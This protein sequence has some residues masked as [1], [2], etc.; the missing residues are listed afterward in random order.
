MKAILL[1][2]MM[3]LFV[4][5]STTTSFK[6]PKGADL[7]IDE[8]KVETA[9]LGKYKRNPFFWTRAQGIPYRLEKKGKVI[10]E[11]KIKARFRVASI[12]WPPA[13]IIYWPL[14]FEEPE[15]DFTKA[16]SL[17]RPEDDYLK[18]KHRK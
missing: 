16:N 11:G 4:G 15:Y 8:Q 5:C 2:V 9:D 17:V 10:D 3:A 18:V 6:V 14:R 12:F 13:A 7:Y 1:V